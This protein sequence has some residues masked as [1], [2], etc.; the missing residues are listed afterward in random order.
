MFFER[1]VTITI[2]YGFVTLLTLRIQTP[3]DRIGLMISISSPQPRIE[4]LI[5][6]QSDT[7]GFLG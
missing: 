3:S 5:P 7:A 6:F 4:G 1:T 2:L